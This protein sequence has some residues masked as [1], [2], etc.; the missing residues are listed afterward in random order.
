V[1]YDAN[2]PR[3]FRQRGQPWLTILRKRPAFRRAF[4][5]FDPGRV[6]GFGE[7]DIQRCLADPGIVRHRGK[8]EATIANARATITV[9]EQVGSLAA[10]VWAFEPS[11]TRSTAARRLG[12]LAST[13]AESTALS[14]ELR[15]YGFRFVGPTTAYASMQSLGVVN[16]HLNGCDFR[17]ACERDRRGLSVPRRK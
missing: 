7:A 9:Q 16:D 17:A 8:I 1:T 4:A 13:T 6:A 15:R 2:P 14:R 12:D 10:L 3:P 5:G 11:R